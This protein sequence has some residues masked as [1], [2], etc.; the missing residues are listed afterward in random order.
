MNKDV[1]E[2]FIKGLFYYKPF[3]KIIDMMTKCITERLEN[4]NRYKEWYE[5]GQKHRCDVHVNNL[6]K[7][8]TFK[9]YYLPILNSLE[10]SIVECRKY[11]DYSINVILDDGTMYDLT[12]FGGNY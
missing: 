2:I 3:D 11:N 7:G 9:I 6:T 1:K 4:V 10:K 12:L 5:L 8:E